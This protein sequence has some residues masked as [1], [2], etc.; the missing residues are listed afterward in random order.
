MGLVRGLGRFEAGVH[1]EVEDVRGPFPT[2]TTQDL[3]FLK[4]FY[5]PP[6]RMPDSNEGSTSQPGLDELITL[7]QA[8][9]LSGIS[10]SHL[11]LLAR[12]GTIWAKKLGHNWFTTAQAVN[13]YLA[14]DRRPGPK[15][16]DQSDNQKD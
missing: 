12:K 16:K 8:A 2:V 10:Y 3:L 14:R 15:P 11:R 6:Y 13:E 7:K 1:D 4:I 9:E 5:N